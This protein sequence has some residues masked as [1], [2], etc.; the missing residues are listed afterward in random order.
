[1]KLSELPI[2]FNIILEFLL[3]TYTF[4][5]Y[6][7]FF[8]RNSVDKIIVHLIYSFNLTFFPADLYV[9]CSVISTITHSQVFMSQ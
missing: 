8:R 3:F 9:L 7:I 4:F 5:K 2:Q 1:V 6:M